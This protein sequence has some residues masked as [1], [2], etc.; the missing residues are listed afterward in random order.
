MGEKENER[1]IAHRIVD[2]VELPAIHIDRVAERLKG[3][4]TD[5]HRKDDLQGHRRGVQPEHRAETSE[6]IGEEI[7]VFEGGEDAQ[8]RQERQQDPRASLPLVLLFF[9][10][11]ADS[12]VDAGRDEQERGKSPVPPAIEHKARDDDQPVLT[13]LA[14]QPVECEHDGIKD[15]ERERREDH[16]SR[17]VLTRAAAVIIAALRA[18]STAN[19]RQQTDDSK[20]T[21][22]TD[23]N[24]RM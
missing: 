20:P 17:G 14:E 5:P 15:R 13:F 6:R 10:G 18:L 4:K 12:E 8:I 24:R 7:E 21:Q 3:I 9:E 19:R 16:E 23:A 22:Q 2:C 11:E 1:K